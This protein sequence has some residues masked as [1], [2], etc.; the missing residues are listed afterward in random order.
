MFI[1]VAMSRGPE[2]P[3]ELPTLPAGTTAMHR[4]VGPVDCIP[5][6]L[7]RSRSG[8]AETNCRSDLDINSSYFAKVCLSCPIDDAYVLPQPHHI[9]YRD[10]CIAM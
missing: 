10:P 9:E 6:G 2:R 5:D 4:L 7:F 1:V 3:T 8:N